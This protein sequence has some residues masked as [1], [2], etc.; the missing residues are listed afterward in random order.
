M[1][2]SYP[3]FYTMFFCNLNPRAHSMFFI[4]LNPNLT[5]GKKIKLDPSRPIRYVWNESRW[6]EVEDLV[7]DTLYKI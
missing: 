3:S 7:P 5:S 1:A 4:N 6:I 2:M